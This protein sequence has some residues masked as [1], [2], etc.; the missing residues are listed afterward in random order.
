MKNINNLL[1]IV[2]IAI[3]L[4]S[5]NG[6]SSADGTKNAKDALS[7]FL[8][9]NDNV[10]AF[11]NANLKGIMTKSDY[12]NIPK[13][14]KILTGEMK[15]LEEMIDFDSPMYYALE[16]PL[17]NGTG[18][19]TTYGFLQIKDSEKLVKKMTKDGFDFTK[20]KNINFTE[21]G[22]F[23]LGLT[24]NMAIVIS[25]SGQFD[26]EK[27][28][29]KAFD[30]IKGKSSGGKIDEILAQEGDVVLGMNV[31]SLY[32]TSDK[33]SS[34]LSVAKQ[35]EIEELVNDSYVQ[36][37]FKF[38]D[39]A[40]IIESKNYF[41]NE[42]EQQLFFKSD[43]SAPILAQLGSG[44]A[45]LGISLNLDMQKMQNFLNDYSPE[46]IDELG[47]ALGPVFQGA[48]MLSG[49]K[50]L[51]AFLD[52]RVGA[53]MIGDPGANGSMI[54]DFNAFVGMTKKGQDLAAMAEDMDFGFGQLNLNDGGVSMSSNE[55]LSSASKGNNLVL[56]D[57]CKDFGKS[58]IS[59]F[60][61]LDGLDM[62][63]FDLEGEQNILKIIKYVTFDY[64]ENGGRLY[65][66]AKKGQDNVLKQAMDVLV[67]ELSSEINSLG[68]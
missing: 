10:V 53:V 26:G 40:G 15:T 3:V 31:S 37:V 59:A 58:G 55:N 16:G 4:F 38:E 68:N 28:I 65:I 27:L 41:S 9:N 49:K 43:N 2:S 61:N 60:V 17:A 39:G 52:G 67:K 22:D 44:N 64:D 24:E 12:Q 30:Q 48:M 42:L 21:D 11:G 34:G 18:P 19:E 51:S 57:G 14:G 36:T 66:K 29:V 46:A 47:N 25:K 6:C 56:P 5:L 63:E 62:D 8:N 54:P 33:S 1:Q 23:A 13:F 50:G 45:R 20:V 35:K 7:S 32:S